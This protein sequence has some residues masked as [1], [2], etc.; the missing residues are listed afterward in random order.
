VL[1]LAAAVGGGA[2]VLVSIVVGARLLGLAAR[3]RQLPELVIGA[4]LLLMAGIS[5][6]ALTVAQTLGESPGLQTGL[7]LASSLAS[8]LGQTLIATFN[9]RVFRSEERWPALLTAAIA[10]WMVSLWLWQAFGPGWGS[11]A[12]THQG[13][14]ALQ[15][16]CSI[17]TMGWGTLE[18]SL[19]YAKLKRRLSLGLADPLVTDRL[20]L[21]AIAMGSSFTTTAI[22]TSLRTAGVPMTGEVTGLF[23]GPLGLISATAMWLAFFPPHR[24]SNWVLARAGAGA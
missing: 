8:L 24:Y 2:F 22:A 14:W 16:G 10:A 12:R 19:Y 4:G 17:V 7:T 21:W 23:V 15:Q 20:R 13:P 9:W 18:S 6:P 5:Y 3:T 1:V 11:F